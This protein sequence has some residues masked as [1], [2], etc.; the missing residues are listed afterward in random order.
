[1]PPVVPSSPTGSA[2]S[3]SDDDENKYNYTL[4]EITDKQ[5]LMD[6]TLQYYCHWIPTA[7]APPGLSWEPSWENEEVSPNSQ[8][9]S[10]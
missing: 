9:E 8:N 6:G 5:L 7:D 4:G 1:M 10:D 2:N 3:N